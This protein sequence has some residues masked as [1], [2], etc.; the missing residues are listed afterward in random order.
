MRRIRNS[1]GIAVFRSFNT[2]QLLHDEFLLSTTV[3]IPK[4]RNANLT[5]SENYRGITLSSV[6]GRLLDLI[7]LNRYSD[8]LNSSELQ[9]GFKRNRSTAMCSMI[10]KEVISYYTNCNSSVHCVFLDSSKAFD[11]I[12]YCK[13]FRLLLDRKISSHVIRILLNMFTNQQI[14]VL[15][16]GVYSCP[17]SVKNGVK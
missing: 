6:F 16:N 2:G 14:R 3:P 1:H 17:L 4:G 11:R 13:L 5:N 10:A 8:Q 9:F 7:I 12:E 15:W